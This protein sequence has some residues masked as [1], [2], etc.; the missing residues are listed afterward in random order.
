ML[1]V[2]NQTIYKWNKRGRLKVIPPAKAQV[3]LEDVER[4]LRE[5]KEASEDESKESTS[6]QRGN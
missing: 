1:G 5:R 3:S 6:I 2:S 4:I